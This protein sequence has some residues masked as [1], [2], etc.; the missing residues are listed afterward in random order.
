[1]RKQRNHLR[2]FRNGGLRHEKKMK[3]GLITMLMLLFPAMLWAGAVQLPQTGQTTCYDASGA[4][5]SCTGTG[6]DGEIQAGAAWP[7]PRFT[8][9]GNQTV[10]DNMTGL[11][12]SK[13]ANTAGATKT[14]QEALD[15]IKTL[16]S[17]N[18]LGHNDW[19]LPN[20]NELASLMDISRYNPALTSGYPFANVQS[21]H[22][23]SSST[24]AN[25][26]NSAWIADIVT[27]YVSSN[28]KTSSCD[29]WP[30]RGGKTG[31]YAS[32]LYA[33]FA[34]AGMD[35]TQVTASNP[36]LLVTGGSTLYGTF[37]GQGIWK[38]DGTNWTQTTTSVPQ[39]IVAHLLTFMVHLP[40]R[41]FGNG[42]EQPPGRRYLRTPQHRWWH[43][44]WSYMQ[45][46]PVS[47]SRNGTAQ[48]GA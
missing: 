20:R 39:M 32:T 10:T 33:K 31:Q 28:D 44:V 41:A 6:Q 37:S 46:F 3:T 5:I 43:P 24:N 40:E 38:F 19:R 27:G 15:Y 12:W 18:Y 35:W 42:M 13:D 30:V 26:T 7:N 14:W 22:Y 2:I 23:W 25:Y 29:V 34:N 48:S 9:N 11:A 21:D 16:N 1:V 4:V 45:S 36:Q 47:A 17:N 8:D